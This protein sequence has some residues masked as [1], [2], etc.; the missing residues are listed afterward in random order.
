ATSTGWPTAAR[1]NGISRGPD[2]DGH[3]P[4]SVNP[5]P[6][7]IDPCDPPPHRRGPDRGR[8]NYRQPKACRPLLPRLRRRK[9]FTILRNP[10]AIAIQLGMGKPPMRTL[11]E[12]TAIAPGVP[13]GTQRS[14][15]IAA[16][17]ASAATS[18]AI[19]AAIMPELIPRAA[20]IAASSASAD[21]TASP[22]MA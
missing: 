21:S 11:G 18:A 19:W 14:L 3:A 17:R 12:P 1:P 15:P 20:C 16:P 6:D 7:A 22:A 10:L 4:R 5:T 9:P 2:I 8:F 13:G